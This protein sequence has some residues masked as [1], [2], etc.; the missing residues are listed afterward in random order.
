MECLEYSSP[1]WT[2]SILVNDQAVKW[3]KA[4]VCVHGHSV[5]CVGQVKDISGATE[6]WR[7]QFE[8][9]KR[10]SSYQ[11]AVGLDGEPIE[12]EWTF[13]P[14][15]SSLSILCEIQNDLV[16]KN[17]KPE[18]FKDR[19]IFMPM[20]NDIEWKK[21]DE[22]CISNAE[23][24]R[25]NVMKFLQGH[26]TFLGPGS[27]ENCMAIPTIKKREWKCTSNKMVQRFKE[28]QRFESWDLE[29]TDRQMYRSLERRFYKYRT[30]VPNSLLCQSAQCL[31]SSCE[32]VAKEKMVFS[33]ESSQAIFEMGNVELIELKT[34]MIQCPSCLHHVFKRDNALPMRHAHKI[35][36]GYDATNQSWFWKAP[37]FRTSAIVAKSCKHGPNLW[38]EH[39][40]KAKD[41][42][43]VV[44]K[45]TSV[46]DRWHRDE[47]YRESHLVH[48]WSGAWV[49]Y[50]D[51]TAT[52]DISHTAPHSQKG[53]Y[54]YLL[55]LRS[56]NEDKQGLPL[57]QRPGYQDKS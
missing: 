36:P 55:Y 29:A 41:A 13:F 47:T 51:H 16:T 33:L 11:D 3:A 20:F 14:G 50:F 18:D 31:R 19:I 37:C 22:K 12:L 38:Q 57:P 45:Y 46:W 32:L 17:I 42:R 4:E 40:H 2:R 48:E 44:R 35:Q 9:L 7:G 30:L 34:S 8:D 28:Y 24:V 52:I 54:N 23:E 43:R 49:R 10:H 27:E 21:N 39:H 56:V 15:F 6:R 1:S 5:L 53:R 25:N 26:W